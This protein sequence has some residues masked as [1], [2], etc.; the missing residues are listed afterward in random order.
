M[1]DFTRRLG[2]A[3]GIA[4]CFAGPAHTHHST[5]AEFDQSKPVK[6]T[7]TV[8]AVE[9]HLC[10]LASAFLV[11]PFDKA[12]AVSVDGFGGADGLKLT[13]VDTVGD[14]F[15]SSTGGLVGSVLA[16]WWLGPRRNAVR[17]ESEAVGLS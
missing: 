11:S 9:H 5:A 3:I 16:V 1:S 6:F 4:L 14:L 10:H 12:V 15:L 8:H 2:M 17:F 7:G 13:Y